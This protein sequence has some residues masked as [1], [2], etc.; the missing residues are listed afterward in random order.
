[1]RRA[2]SNATARTLAVDSSGR[3]TRRRVCWCAAT[4]ASYRLSSSKVPPSVRPPTVASAA[5]VDASSREASKAAQPSVPELDAKAAEQVRLAQEMGEEAFGEN[6][7]ILSQVGYRGLRAFVVCAIGMSA[8]MLAMKKKK[9]ELA[10]E[11]A[12]DDPTQRYLEEM[13]SLGFDVDT[14]EEELEQ[15]RVAKLATAPTEKAAV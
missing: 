5:H 2:V 10:T 7:E 15:E 12:D 14:L 11:E 6:T 8:L 3:L 1:M 9:A 4:L 13:R